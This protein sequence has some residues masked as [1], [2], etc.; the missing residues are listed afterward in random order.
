MVEDKNNEK[1]GFAGLNHLVSDVE[2]TNSTPASEPTL[3]PERTRQ[4]ETPQEPAQPIYFGKPQARSSSSGKYWAIGIGVFVLFVWI[5][6][7]GSNKSAPTRSVVVAPSPAPRYAPTPTCAPAPTVDLTSTCEEKLVKDQNYLMVN[8][9]LEKTLGKFMPADS[10]YL[11][12]IG[13]GQREK[14]FCVSAE[15]INRI[16]DLMYVG[17]SGITLNVIKNHFDS[18]IDTGVVKFIIFNVKASELEVKSESDFEYMGGYGRADANLKLVALNSKGKMGWVTTSDDMA[19]GYA[20]RGISIFSESRRNIKEIL[21]LQTFS[22]DSD[23]CTDDSGCE[24]HTV[25][26]VASLTP[27]AG[28]EFSPIKLQLEKS[29]SM[30]NKV[31]KTSATYTIEF[32]EKSQAYL[33]P[34]DYLKL[35]SFK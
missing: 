8:E 7:S 13:E 33:V 11:A 24:L 16:E 34:P 21:T 20:F 23:A 14:D 6:S 27:K 2:P 30:K 32:S 22:D 3:D 29:V 15:S 10:C 12:R 28:V 17:L 26:A 1:K 25:N 5:S 18:H 19:Q 31:K 4:S 9:Y 35:F